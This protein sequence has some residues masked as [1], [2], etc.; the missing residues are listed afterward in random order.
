MREL[1][2]VRCDTRGYVTDPSLHDDYCVSVRLTKTD[3]ELSLQCDEEGTRREIIL[4]NLKQLLMNGFRQENIVLNFRV[5]HDAS[6]TDRVAEMYEMRP[7]EP[8][9]C[10][11]MADIV[12]GTLAFVSLDCSFGCTLWAVCEAVH[13]IEPMRRGESC[14][15]EP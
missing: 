13:V 9:I 1:R 11:L 5:L 12:S 4:Q 14:T 3:V 15:D 10:T 7:D 6:V 8:Y 2:E